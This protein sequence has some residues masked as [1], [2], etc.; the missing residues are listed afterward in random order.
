[1]PKLIKLEDY[2]NIK[3]PHSKLLYRIAKENKLSI[4]DLAIELDC[5]TTYIRAILNGNQHLSVK[6]A[7]LIRRKYDTSS[8]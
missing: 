2:K 5:S 4:N 7:S 1:M 3:K 6:R 8:N